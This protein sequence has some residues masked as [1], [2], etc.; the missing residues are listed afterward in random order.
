MFILSNSINIGQYMKVKNTEL[1][2]IRSASA[3]AKLLHQEPDII[4]ELTGVVAAKRHNPRFYPI[5]KAD[6][7]GTDNN[8]RPGILVEDTITS[9]F[10]RDFYLQSHSGLKGTAKPTYYF[11]LEDEIG[12]A[13]EGLQQFVSH[14][15]LTSSHRTSSSF[16]GN[17]PSPTVCT[18]MIGTGTERPPG[19]QTVEHMM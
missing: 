17:S 10:F 8:C 2:A 13:V 14:Y 9:P 12:L 18:Q 16:L 15:A 7:Q 6:M 19:G 11:V 5:D 3:K 4:L 1:G